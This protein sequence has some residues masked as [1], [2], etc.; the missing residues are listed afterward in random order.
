VKDLGGLLAADASLLKPDQNIALAAIKKVITEIN[1]FCREGQST[2][3]DK[4]K[5]GSILDKELI[6]LFPLFFSLQV[7]FFRCS[8]TQ[9]QRCSSVSWFP[10]SLFFLPHL[11]LV[12]LLFTG[13]HA[14]NTFLFA[15]FFTPS[16]CSFR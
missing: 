4:Q 11:V 16:F 6:F 10:F 3:T 14:L 12:L 13:Q 5:E 9:E 15:S 2:C 7:F 1:R 8:H